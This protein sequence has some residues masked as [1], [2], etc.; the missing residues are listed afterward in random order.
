MNHAS[1]IF[2]Q[3]ARIPQNAVRPPVTR[4]TPQKRDYMF[5][6]FKFKNW[7]MPVKKR[8]WAFAAVIL[9]R[10]KRVTRF[11]VGVHA[12]H[13]SWEKAVGVV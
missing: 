4:N 9:D 6:D 1:S 13:K 2:L 7:A 10:V 3:S 8:R 12:A 5:D 11:K